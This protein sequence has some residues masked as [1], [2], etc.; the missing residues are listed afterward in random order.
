MTAQKSKQQ[1]N[2]LNIKSHFSFIIFLFVFFTSCKRD[3]PSPHLQ[4]AK[5]PLLNSMEYSDDFGTTSYREQ[6]TYLPIDSSL[7]KI[8]YNYKTVSGIEGDYSYRFE[9]NGSIVTSQSYSNDGQPV[10]FSRTDFTLGSANVVTSSYYKT[11]DNITRVTIYDYNNAGYLTKM[12]I[13]EDGKLKFLREFYYNNNILDSCIL[14]Q[15]YTNLPKKIFLS[16]FEYD[17]AKPNTVG[18][19]YMMQGLMIAGINASK[20][21]GREQKYALKKEVDYRFDGLTMPYIYQEFIY[22]NMYDLGNLL[23]ERNALITVH[24]PGANKIVIKRNYKYAYK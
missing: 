24:Q 1:S 12:S 3:T 5:L 16:V 23:K 11:I 19:Y 15:Y 17:K 9:K 2:L 22:T 4:D 7:L 21:F 18:N 8:Q 10:T 14:F 13:T 6:L 20:I